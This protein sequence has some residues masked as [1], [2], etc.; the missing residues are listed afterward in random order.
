[1]A[2]RR[3]R[4][5]R[6]N[7]VVV[8]RLLCAVVCAT[9][10]LMTHGPRCGA[11]VSVDR[12]T[13]ALRYWPAISS[14]DRMACADWL[15]RQLVAATVCERVQAVRLCMCERSTVFAVSCEEHTSTARYLE[16]NGAHGACIRP[17]AGCVR[18]LCRVCVCTCGNVEKR[19]VQCIGNGK[20]GYITPIQQHR[21]KL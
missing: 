21:T 17:V 4:M 13:A 11:I 1:M 9:R 16:W 8:G 10:A 20:N 15:R 14:S 5:C 7:A 2:E 6:S 18:A 3:M 19:V 12:V